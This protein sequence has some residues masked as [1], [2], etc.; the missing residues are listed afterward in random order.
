MNN[1]QLFE[2]NCLSEKIRKLKKVLLLA[3]KTHTKITTC[4][5]VNDEFNHYLTVSPSVEKMISEMVTK[6]LQ[7]QLKSLQKQFDE[8]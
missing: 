5:V 7:S 8:L 3:G 2:G 1:K 4:F 6:D